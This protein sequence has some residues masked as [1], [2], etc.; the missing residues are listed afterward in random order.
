VRLNVK[1]KEERKKREATKCLPMLLDDEECC[2]I[3]N[4]LD[5]LAVSRKRRKREEDVRE[6]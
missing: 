3:Q 2:T 1:N 5:S 6:E 4:Y